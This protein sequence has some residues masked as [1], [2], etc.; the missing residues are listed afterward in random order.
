MNILIVHQYYLRPGQGG[1][2]RFNVM[3]RAWAEAGHTVTVLA[4]QV[5]YTDGHKA[6][7]YHHKLWRWE[8]DG[9]V[10]V[11][12]THSPA[13]FGRSF[14]GR[15]WSFVAWAAG[16][17]VAA[18]G[19]EADVVVASSPS[20]LAALPGM[21]HRF[22]RGSR[23]VFEVRDLWPES[24]VTTGVLG[25]DAL[26]TRLLYNLEWA[27]CKAAHRVNALTPAIAQDMRARGLI[28]RWWMHPNGAN[29]RAFDAVEDAHTRALR[30]RL[31]WQGRT[32]LLYAGAHGLANDLGQLL[33]LA[34]RLAHR[35]EVLLVA[36]GAGPQKDALVAR[37]RA[38]KLENIQWL[39]PV[40]A[41]EVPV[42]YCAADVGLIFL[43]DN[44]TFRSVY[45]NK[46][47][48]IMAA[49]RP[50]LST[51]QGASAQVLDDSQGGRWGDLKVLADATLGW[52]E[53]PDEMR[54]EGARARAW[55]EAHFDR[56]AIARAYLEDLEAL[57]SEP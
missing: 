9:R 50:V 51:V 10:R 17:C 13:T 42:Y 1:G 46:M 29:L 14:A 36:L 53:R 52:L 26:L 32:V 35:P 8:R 47:F 3:A 41:Q 4:G 6:P 5:D 27:A 7:V 21:A 25:P 56:A 37:A 28:T 18:L 12:R 19:L 34:Q 24:A 57:V 31:G 11:L 33:D 43:Q 22:V 20:L 48:D 40:S 15:A 45:P 49:R 44:P 39:D 38:R 23:L 54:A 16:A 2:A 55:V 30:A